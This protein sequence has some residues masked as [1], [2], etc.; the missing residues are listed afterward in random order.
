MNGRERILA[1]LEGRPADC[2]P[3]MPITMTFASRWI[4]V[5]YREYCTN[6]KVHAEGQVRVATEFDIDYVSSISDPAIESTDCGSPTVWY[7]DDPPA[8]N[9]AYALLADKAKLDSLAL[10][11]IKAG[12]RMMNRINCVGELK[13]RIGHEKAVEGWIEGPAAEG[14]DLRGIN[15]LMLDFYDDPGFVERLFEFVFANAMKF[16][17][18]QVD[19]GADIIGIGDAAASLVGPAIYSEMVWPH[20]KKMVEGVQKL[21]AKARLHIC[22]NTRRILGGMGTLGCDIVDLDYFSSLEEGRRAMGKSQV[23]LGN[24]D[25]VRVLRNGT[26]GEVRDAIEECHLHAGARYI[27]GAGC[28]VVRDTP[29]DNLRAL[30]EYA[31]THAPLTPTLSQ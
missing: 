29:H 14:A 12:T 27:V 20:E 25:P 28:E 3:A 13:R 1:M 2:L 30:I 15:N 4:G 31:K 23:L 24:I 8:N 19:A 17:A 18:A 11:E 6:Y 26:P 5:P 7:E 22:G 9:E 16:A 10:P 21:G